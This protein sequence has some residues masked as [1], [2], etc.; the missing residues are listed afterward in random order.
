MH[1]TDM[2]TPNRLRAASALCLLVPVPSLAVLAAMWIWPDTK[3]GMGLFALAK[4]WL[5]VFPVLWYVKVERGKWSLSP[6]KRGGFGIATVLGLVIVGIIVAGYFA[7]KSLGWVDPAATREL[8]SGKGLDHRLLYIGFSLQAIFINALVEEY[9]WRWFVFR[10]WEK[11]IGGIGAVVA[12]ALCFTLHHIF[13]LA[14]YFDWPATL[15]ASAGVFV[16]GAVWSWC[17]LRYRSIWPGYV[18]HAIVDVP[19]FVIGYIILFG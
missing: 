18:S 12:S 10:Q 6:A 11:L 16:G 7:A 1:V 15:A 14:S 8:L 17:Y 4:V 19:I 5:W 13:A 3:L 9:V 2:N